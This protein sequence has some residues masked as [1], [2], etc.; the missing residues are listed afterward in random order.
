[1]D[2]L[3]RLAGLKCPLAEL[4]VE[5]AAIPMLAGEAAR[6][7]TAGFNPRPVTAADFVKLYEAAFVPG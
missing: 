2:K 6:Q 4:G 7:W 5:R 3:L 1:L